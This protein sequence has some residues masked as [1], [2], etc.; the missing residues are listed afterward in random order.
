M[1]SDEFSS[2]YGRI[3]D[4][5]PNYVEYRQNGQKLVQNDDEGENLLREQ[6]YRQMTFH[7]ERLNKER[8]R[9]S[10]WHT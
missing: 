3:E 7:R 6:V 5:P 2:F 1:M 9:E 4:E 8:E 10:Y